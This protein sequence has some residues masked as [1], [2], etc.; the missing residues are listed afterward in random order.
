MIK[1]AVD[2]RPDD[3][4]MVDSLGW[5]NYRLGQ[6]DEAV[7]QLER[8]VSLKPSDPTI[9]DHLGDAYWKAGRK[10]EATFQW[11][12]A[13]DSKP[14]EDEKA[15]LELKMKQGMK[16]TASADAGKPAADATIKAVNA[17]AA[18]KAPESPK[19][20]DAVKPIDA[21]KPANAPKL[22]PP[23]PPAPAK[24]NGG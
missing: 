21:P 17:P 9:N 6:Y 11:R 13:L 22:V 3:G 20:V 10:L 2:Q 4:Y 12:H 19:P 5:A 7:E 23:A 14:D 15:D 8:A 16:D 18:A 24:G 1:K